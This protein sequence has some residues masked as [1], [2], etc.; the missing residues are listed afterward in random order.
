MYPLASVYNHERTLYTF[1]QNDLTNNQWYE[2]F[3][4]RSDVVNTIGVTR[5]RKVLLGQVAQEKHSGSLK[6]ITEQE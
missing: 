5:Q 3:N 2:K 1:H 4:T 6:N